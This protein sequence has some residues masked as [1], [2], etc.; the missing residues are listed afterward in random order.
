[1]VL[2]LCIAGPC[3]LLTLSHHFR[4]RPVRLRRQRISMRR[5]AF[6]SCRR[7]RRLL[8]LHGRVHLQH[9]LHLRGV[10]LCH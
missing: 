3:V 5:C 4:S 9:L 6:A 7:R 1:M 2:G 10:H 8:R